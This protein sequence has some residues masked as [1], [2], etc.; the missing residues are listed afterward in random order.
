MS[1]SPIILWF[2]DD[3][4][5]SDHAPLRAA[6]AT[7]APLIPLFVLDDQ[8]PGPWRLGGASR[9]WLH[10]SLAALAADLSARGGAARRPPG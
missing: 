8:T 5:L 7:G 10:H 1:A 3:L 9:W 2:R 4:R 6:V